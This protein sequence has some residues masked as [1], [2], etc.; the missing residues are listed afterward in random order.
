MRLGILVRGLVFALDVESRVSAPAAVDME[1][2][3][4][5]QSRPSQ[6]SNTRRKRPLA[7]AAC[8][9]CRRLKKRCDAARPVCGSCQHV[10]APCHYETNDINESRFQAV[11]RHQQD[12]ESFQQTVNES[13]V[14]L[15]SQGPETI[16][17]CLRRLKDVDVADATRELC[18]IVAD[19]RAERISPRI[20]VQNMP[21]ASSLSLHE[22]FDPKLSIQHPMVYPWSLDGGSRWEESTARALK[23]DPSSVPWPYLSDRPL[24][25]SG[26]RPDTYSNDLPS[27]LG[28]YDERLRLLRIDYWTTVPVPSELAAQVLSTYLRV[29]HPIYSFFDPDLFLGDLIA[30]EIQ[31][32]SPLLVNA[33]LFWAGCTFRPVH[34]AISNYIEGFLET[35]QSLLLAEQNVNTGLNV[36]ALMILALGSICDGKD[37]LGKKCMVAGVK[38]AEAMHLIGEQRYTVDQYVGL[39]PR[40]LSTLVHAAWGAFNFSTTLPAASSFRSVQLSQPLDLSTA[41]TFPFFCDFWCIAHQVGSVYYNS[42]APILQRVPLAFV[43]S[44]L[45]SLLQ[46]AAELP[47]E[48]G[49]RAG[50]FAVPVS[51]RSPST[52]DDLRPLLPPAQGPDVVLPRLLRRHGGIPHDLVGPRAAVRRAHHPAPRQGRARAAR[53]PALPRRLRGARA[54]AS[55]DGRGAARLPGHGHLGG[56]PHRGAGAEVLRGAAA[57]ER[58]R[59]GPA[60]DGVRGGSGSGRRGPCGG[61][62]ERAGAAV[63]RAAAV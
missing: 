47:R 38:M 35:A 42:T 41:S 27:A 32:C 63:R 1:R 21:L 13:L 3:T 11:K 29:E 50:A 18:S 54:V 56:D 31:Y 23:I 6:S 7:L 2:K 30:N 20:S 19:R 60:G 33:L 53:L 34:P 25:E 40:M 10:R 26:V 46:W 57:R 48:L 37:G 52:R 44:K 16:V 14:W 51:L 17:A 43:Q 55:H 58:A 28:S 15:H 5:G 22:S 39:S 61:G 59:P 24:L 9:R 36:A 49:R 45:H 8:A 12:A 4:Q 62:R